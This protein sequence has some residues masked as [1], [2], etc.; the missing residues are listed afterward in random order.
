M[1]GIDSGNPKTKS[2]WRKPQGITGLLVLGGIGYLLYLALPYLI[3]FT[4]NVVYLGIM[5]GAI[6]IASYVIIDNR[7]MLWYLYKIL[8]Y[9]ITKQVYTAIDPIA[10]AKVYINHLIDK[11]NDINEQIIKLNGNIKS[12][13]AQIDANTKQSKN[14]KAEAQ[15]AQERN[16]GS[17]AILA[18]KEALRLED[19]N[20]DLQPLLDNMTKTYSFLKKMYDIADYI[21][22]DK[23]NEID[24]MEKKYKSV[25]IAL[26]ALKSANAVMGQDAKDA[27]FEQA[28]D[29]IKDDMANKLGEMDR[30][31]DLATPY[32]NEFD[33]QQA[34]N[35]DRANDLLKSFN[36]SAFTTGLGNLESKTTNPIIISNQ[37]SATPVLKSSN[38]VAPTQKVEEAA[39]DNFFK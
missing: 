28:M 34:V 23:T 31:L 11:K 5:V 1:T 13:Q 27:G 24:I 4:E 36:E 26:S 7:N 22:K 33:L 30:I 18:S 35:D 29:F 39:F 10:T 9:N 37:A 2:F 19:W 32:I 21:I 3:Q 15:A 16:M 8:M 25:K 17:V 6:G 14:K 38:K 12:T 20:K